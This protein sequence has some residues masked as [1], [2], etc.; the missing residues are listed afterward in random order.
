MSEPRNTQSIKSIAT[1]LLANATS[2]NGLTTDEIAA[3]TK[4]HRT[5]VN[6]IVNNQPG[7]SKSIEPIWPFG[8]YYS[9]ALAQS[10]MNGRALQKARDNH[11]D[12]KVISTI[13]GN[14]ILQEIVGDRVKNNERE[15]LEIIPRL[16][17]AATRADG[18]KPHMAGARFVNDPELQKKWFHDFV[19]LMNA[20]RQFYEYSVELLESEEF[21]E[22]DFWK[23]FV[24]PV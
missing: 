16:A 22:P 5:T 8:Y 24:K 3:M 20:C 2:R 14:A 12:E 19:N 6:R 1:V 11:H 17:E 13:L 9:H 18:I 15:I 23:V 7:F 10:K 21:S 4:L